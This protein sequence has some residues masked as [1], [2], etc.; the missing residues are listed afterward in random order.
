MKYYAHLVQKGEG[1]DYTIGCANTLIEIDAISDE[2]AI[3]KLS[4]E[5]KESFTYDRELSSVKLFKEEIP[6][7]LESVYS[8][9]NSYKD[10]E[11]KRLRH[12]KDREEYERLKSKFGE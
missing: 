11:N 1:C 12:L 7:D 9:F 2:E 4:E 8:E 3:K 10:S 5:I 6:F